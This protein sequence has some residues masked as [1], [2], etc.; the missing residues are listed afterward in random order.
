MRAVVTTAI[1][2]LGV[3]LAVGGFRGFPFSL[4]MLLGAAV[5]LVPSVW[6]ALSLTSGRSLLGPIWLGLMRYTLAAAGF[7]ML[8]ALRPGSDP[9]AVIAGSAMTLLLSS[10]LVGWFQ[11]RAKSS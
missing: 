9:L 6:V 5:V 2:V 7:A 4:D 3:A 8:F 11:G 10:A 1:V